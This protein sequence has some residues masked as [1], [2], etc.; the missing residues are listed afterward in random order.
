LSI[1]HF[2]VGKAKGLRQAEGGVR[3]S[4]LPISRPIPAMFPLSFHYLF[5]ILGNSGSITMGLDRNKEKRKDA[6]RERLKRVSI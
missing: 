3:E 5:Q 1:Q 4:F 2:K 6:E